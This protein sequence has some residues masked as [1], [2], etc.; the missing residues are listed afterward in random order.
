[1]WYYMEVSE[2]MGLPPAII[3]VNGIFPAKSVKTPAVK[4]M[5]KSHTYDLRSNWFKKQQSLADS[6][7]PCCPIYRF[8]ADLVNYI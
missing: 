6:C 7:L 4:P 1:M 2:V 5:Y 3:H 8:V